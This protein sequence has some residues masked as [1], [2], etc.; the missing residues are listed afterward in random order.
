MNKFK[1][2]IFVIIFLIF[3]YA[4]SKDIIHIVSASIDYI[5]NQESEKLFTE[6]KINFD[7]TVIVKNKSNK[8][9]FFLTEAA[10]AV[11]E[12]PKLIL[13]EA[14]IA[15]D[16]RPKLILAEAA[17]AVDEKSE[18]TA[19][20]KFN[21]FSKDFIDVISADMLNKKI[22]ISPN[23][24]IS[25]IQIL[26]KPNDLEL[27]LKY[28]RQ[29]GE[30]GNH[31]QTIS[32]LERLIMLYPEN[33]EI[34]FYLLSVLVQADSPTKAL[35]LIND[36]KTL[37]GLSSE[38]LETIN[39]AEEYLNEENEPKLWNFYADLSLGGI[40]SNNV[41]NV[42]NT[43]KKTTSDVVEE[44]GSARYDHTLSEGLGLTATRTVGEVSSLIFNFNGSASQQD[45]ETTD[46]FNSLG[47]MV[48]FDTSFGDHGVSPYIMFSETDNKTAAENHALI[49][50]FGNY[51]SINDKNSINY[52]FSY[53]DAKSD[54]NSSYATADATNSIDHTYNI[55]HDFILNKLVS[56]STSITYAISDAK[57]ATNDYEN[58]DLGLRLNLA[59]PFAY[60]SIGNYT[61]VNDYAIKD[62]SINSN[63]LRTDLTNTFDVIATK[64]LGDIFPKYDPNR[65][66]F[67]SIAY[68]NIIS[69]SN[70][71]NYDYTAESFTLGLTKTVHLNK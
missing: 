47:L 8:Q 40:F 25:Y 41:N 32:T 61:S 53:A 26:Q 7:D 3:S 19:D 10:I 16:E 70:I 71:L 46:N 45:Q 48:A 69:E 68:E 66:L 28:A 54:N 63:I 52:G 23:K 24:N 67:F 4:Y 29:Q 35:D 60:I 50:G 9:N 38:D 33:A 5:T 12:R 57:D 55:G 62:P 6:S 30:S 1:T 11:D 37:S 17:I 31:K 27:N 51:F 43:G 44:F 14:A 42:S 56:T 22:I 58:Y 2:Y 21:P 39:E 15:V 13:A 36:I 18:L 64:A 34:K 59:F 20:K 49:W 65:T